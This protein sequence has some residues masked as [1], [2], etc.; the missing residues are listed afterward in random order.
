[1][2]PKE[3]KESLSD[4]GEPID[5]KLLQGFAKVSLSDLDSA[6]EWFDENASPEWVGALKNKPI[7]K[8]KK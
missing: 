5:P 6:I 1:M 7:G 3:N 4:F 2:E 8:G